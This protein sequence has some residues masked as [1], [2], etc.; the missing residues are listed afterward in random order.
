MHQSINGERSW[1]TLSKG[2]QTVKAFGQNQSQRQRI[3]DEP[4]FTE[5]N[6]SKSPRYHND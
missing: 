2:D 6:S 1:N 5:Y 3:E 4:V